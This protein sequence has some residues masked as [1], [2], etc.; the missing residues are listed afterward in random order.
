[1]EDIKKLKKK[2]NKIS[3]LYVISSSVLLLLLLG[4][5][6]YGVYL[7]VGL[8]FV[9][10]GVSNI[11]DGSA[12]NVSY[13]NFNNANSMIGVTVLSVALIIISIL[14]IISLIKQI[15]LFKQFKII[16]DSKLTKKLEKKS[17]NKTKVIV[18]A[19][20]ID[21]LS[22]VCGVIGI[23][24]NM[25]CFS[26]GSMCYG[27]YIIDGFVS[28]LALA[29]I[30]LLILKYKKLKHLKENIEENNEIFYECEKDNDD[31]FESLSSQKDINNETQDENNKIEIN[32]CPNDENQEDSQEQLEKNTETEG[33]NMQIETEKEDEFNIDEIEYK[34]LKLK[35][36]KTTR[37]IT[38][39]EYDFL[40]SNILGTSNLNYNDEQTFQND[41]SENK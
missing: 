12:M 18:F 9:R 25:R 38:K 17:K 37:M 6:I 29:N 41:S 28:V 24:V 8:S 10:N 22:F 33:E 27:L 30:V 23:F 7:S 32:I 3:L 13:N 26:S 2:S 40:R 21:I 20:F 36:L 1:M 19:V 5:G 31:S 4:G 39:Q 35:Q 16:E 11:A 14:D 15:I 34:L